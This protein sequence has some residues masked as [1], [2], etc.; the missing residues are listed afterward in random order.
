M[1]LKIVFIKLID[2]IESQLAVEF[3]EKGLSE[4]KLISPSVH[5][6]SMDSRTELKN[7]ITRSS[8]NRSTGRKSLKVSKLGLS[9]LYFNKQN[10]ANKIFYLSLITIG[11]S[12]T[13]IV[14]GLVIAFIEKSQANLGIIISVSSIFS[15][16]VSG[17]SFWFYKKEN[18]NLKPVEHDIKKITRLELFLELSGYISDEKQR[19]KAYESIIKK[20]NK[21]KSSIKKILILS[22]NPEDGSRLRLDK[23]VCEIE[24]GLER[25]LYRAQFNI[26]SKWA[27]SFWDLR[28]A[29]LEYKPHFVHFAGHGEEEG[30][31]VE[32][33]HGFS[34]PI[35][36]KALFGLFE[37]CS[38]NLE[39][40]ILN[41][42]HSEI[43]ADIIN[44]HIK[45]VIG[46]PG[47]ITDQAA[48]EFAVGFYDALGAGNT[49]EKAFKLGCNAIQQILPDLP[50][51]LFPV[52]KNK[53]R[54]DQ[55]LKTDRFNKKRGKSNDL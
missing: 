30:L 10:K 44:K 1:N 8:L 21:R 7:E 41:A 15:G 27:V 17:T 34:V 2:S 49:V 25:A 35:S 3:L 52:L 20:I 4:T 28:R 36:S 55:T 48:I 9:E 45:Y 6:N 39:C 14:I 32:S 40:V 29:L 16:Y 54:H 37:L 18:L 43:Q 33:D 23:E 26:Q 13:L 53:K 31:L 19:S 11:I 50:K 46:M 24:K 47:K 51:K 5:L 42:C 38:D 22:A 12:L